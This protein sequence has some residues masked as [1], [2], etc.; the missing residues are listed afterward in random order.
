MRDVLCI[1]KMVLGQLEYTMLCREKLDT[2]YLPSSPLSCPDCAH[3][4]QYLFQL[5]E[6]IY[7][8]D[9]KN[10]RKRV[11]WGIYCPSCHIQYVLL[12]KL[13]RKE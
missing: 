12:Y 1:Q 8:T 7:I 13:N 5:D 9:I 11:H 6:E 3:D 10:E 2:R 4:G